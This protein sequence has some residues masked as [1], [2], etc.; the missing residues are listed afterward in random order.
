MKA[1][2]IVIIMYV[3]KGKFH[4]VYQCIVVLKQESRDLKWSGYHFIVWNANTDLKRFRVLYFKHWKLGTK[5]KLCFSSNGTLALSWFYYP[6]HHKNISLWDSLKT[7]HWLQERG[8]NLLFQVSR[9]IR[10][11]YLLVYNITLSLGSW[12]MPANLPVGICYIQFIFMCINCLLTGWYFHYLMYCI[13][14]IIIPCS[15]LFYN[16]PC[17]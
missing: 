14:L 12:K 15:L 5:S 9:R 10:Y 4:T 6:H 17:Q 16:M 13:L 8:L 3:S 11:V 1:F 7:I 2:W